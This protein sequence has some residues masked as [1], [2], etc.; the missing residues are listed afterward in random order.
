M[1]AAGGSALGTALTSHTTSAVQMDF[2]RNVHIDAMRSAKETGASALTNKG[3]SQTADSAPGVATWEV[4]L[5]AR[6]V[7]PCVR[8]PATGTTARSLQPSPRLR[9]HALQLGGDVEQPWL[10]SKHDV[11]RKPESTQH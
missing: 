7:A 9:V 3:Q 4:T 5:S 2:Q 10:T 11:I 1:Q 8:W 6:K